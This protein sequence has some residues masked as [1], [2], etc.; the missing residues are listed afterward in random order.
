MDAE[1]NVVKALSDAVDALVSK[2]TAL[3]NRIANQSADLD[4]KLHAVLSVEGG[5]RWR[6]LGEYID[7]MELNGDH[8]TRLQRGWISRRVLILRVW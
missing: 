5:D 6:L 4:S 8:W 1:S 7:R 3:E 2:L